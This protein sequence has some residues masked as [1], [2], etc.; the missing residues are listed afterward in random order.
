MEDIILSPVPTQQR[1]TVEF[2]EL[3][4]SYFFS[5][6]IK[7]SY[8]LNKHI[9][10]IWIISFPIFFIIASGS[11]SLKNNLYYWIILSILC[12]SLVPLLLISRQFL[13]WNYIY[14][15]LLSNKIIYE[16]SDWHDGKVWVKP[17]TWKS[18]DQ[19]IAKQEVVPIIANIKSSFLYLILMILLVF[20]SFIL[21]YY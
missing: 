8:Y 20:S 16:E 10:I 3:S 9:T 14:R 7:S 1:P 2:T 21:E 19:L 11:P 17:D 15:R 4:N 18:R 5:W 6:P 13:G 12:S